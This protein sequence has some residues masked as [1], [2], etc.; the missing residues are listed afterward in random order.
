M[1][2]C[3]FCR[4][5]SDDEEDLAMIQARVNAGDPMALFHLGTKYHL[6]EYG[7]EKNMTRAVELY[8]SAAELGVKDAHYNLGLMYANGEDVEKDT[9][10]AFRHYEAAA[11]CGHVFARCNLGCE[12]YNAGNCELALQHL[13]ISAKLGDD[14]SLKNVRIFS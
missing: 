5:H 1:R 6:G 13:L 2:D 4:T 8:E 14:E 7:L 9:N 10:K 12:E 11:M 3:P